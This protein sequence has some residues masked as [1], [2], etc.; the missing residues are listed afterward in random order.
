MRYNDSGERK[1][2]VVSVGEDG[3]IRVWSIDK[4]IEVATL[5]GHECQSIWKVHSAELQFDNMEGNKTEII[6][7]GAN[8]G[9]AKIWDLEYHIQNN[10]VTITGTDLCT[11]TEFIGGDNVHKFLIPEDNI[12]YKTDYDVLITREDAEKIGHRNGGNDGNSSS[13]I[14]VAK[15]KK[16][17]SMKMGQAICGMNFYP[18]SSERNGLLLVTRT[19]L[20]CTLCLNTESWQKHAP[21]ADSIIP[22]DVDSCINRVNPSTGSCSAIHPI[23]PIVTVGTTRGQI[24][25]ALLTNAKDS[26]Y[27]FTFSASKYLAVQGIRWIDSQNLLSFH[28]KGIVV[29]W[30]LPLTFS[31]DCL[32]DALQS[33]NRPYINRVFSLNVNG[34]TVGVPMSSFYDAS[35]SIIFIGDS[36]G[37]IA[38]FDMDKKEEKVITPHDSDDIRDFVNI[39]EQLPVDILNFLHKKEHVT[40]IIP[41]SDGRGILSVGNDGR[42]QECTL[43]NGKP[44]KLKRGISRPVSH[45]SKPD[46]IWLVQHAE[47][48]LNSIIVGGFH[49]NKYVVCDLTLGYRFFTV[50]TGGKQRRYDLSL[51]FACNFSYNSPTKQKLA[52]C[53]TKKDGPNEIVVF[54][55]ASNNL[56]KCHSE[57]YLLPLK[58]SVN[59]PCHG[60]TVLD[61]QFCK[62]SRR[63]SL[64]LLSGS[65]DGSCKLHLVTEGSISLI[66]ELPPHES[67][68]RAVC[69]SNHKG[70]LSSLLVVGGGKLGMTF[71]LVDEISLNKDCSI[72]R[73]DFSVYILCQN[74]L[75]FQPS[76]DHRINAVKAIPLIRNG[77]TDY[78]HLVLSGDSNGGLHLTVVE[79][80]IPQPRNLKSTTLMLDG[81]PILSIDMIRIN[82]NWILACIG[83]TEGKISIWLLPGLIEGLK[84]KHPTEPVLVLKKHQMGTN[85][86]SMSIVKASSESDKDHFNVL[87]GSGG[88]D[89]AIV[90]CLLAVI[91]P[92]SENEDIIVRLDTSF[93]AKEASSSAIKGVEIIGGIW[94]DVKEP[95]SNRGKKKSCQALNN[96]IR[97]NDLLVQKLSSV[98]SGDILRL[99]SV[100]Y[101]QRMAI[102]NIDIEGLK[103]RSPDA[104]MFLSSTP[105]DVFDVNCLDCCRIEREDGKIMEMFIAG[106]EG[107]ELLSLDLRS[108]V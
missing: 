26:C 23:H 53:A 76:I 39:A 91:I 56:N 63:G 65:N 3:T 84:E 34:V 28:V 4:G 87:V 22:R 86:I 74:S 30:T 83:D 36:R 93:I 50:N 19:G 70:A 78:L 94:N 41:T 47:D 6:I 75:P 7:T 52:I 105:I 60:E 24:V 25:M 82:E 99:V 107:L 29:L 21:W 71:Y 103:A 51:D 38:V 11:R 73:D 33:T 40:C 62:T 49:G 102:W 37:N 59:S 79:E 68:I 32:P 13:T 64:L 108:L 58:Y 18:K 61:V 45:I 5:S 10:A 12:P 67:C 97:T 89:Q 104:L 42:I 80:K 20:L 9:T 95:E 46:R 27:R 54:S 90:L 31:A 88:D 2:G 72:T 77:H 43:S 106:G 48:N 66:K 92:R 81:R 15:K 55:T 44:V 8:D 57:G 85:C 98:P 35:R 17:K 14:K 101:D 69:S 96:L 1:D 100:G 16:S